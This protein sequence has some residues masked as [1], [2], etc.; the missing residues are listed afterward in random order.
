MSPCTELY[1]HYYPLGTFHPHAACSERTWIK[2]YVNMH[3]IDSLHLDSTSICT[4]YVLSVHEEYIVL[5]IHFSFIPL[6]SLEKHAL[7]NT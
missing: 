7:T 3:Q 4:L 1:C 5:P 2:G 6:F